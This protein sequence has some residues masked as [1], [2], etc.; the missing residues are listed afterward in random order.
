MAALT[1]GRLIEL[2]AKLPSDTKIYTAGMEGIHFA[3]LGNIFPLK[4]LQSKDFG[5]AM[6]IDDGLADH[7][8]ISVG[9]QPLDEFVNC[10]SKML[11]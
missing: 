4:V 7:G 6:F 8:R 5:C 1:V 3:E 11:Q 2:L 10:E 9:W